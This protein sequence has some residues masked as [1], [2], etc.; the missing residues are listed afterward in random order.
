M[1]NK[2]SSFAGI[3]L[4]TGCDTVT[5]CQPPV[6]AR[7]QAPGQLIAM[8]TFRRLVPTVTAE[9]EGKR[10]G[11]LT[12]LIS[13]MPLCS[14]TLANWFMCRHGSSKLEKAEI[15]QMTVDHLKLLHA[16]GGKG[17][18]DAHALAVDYRSLGFRECVGEVA[19]FLSSLESLQN[20]DPIGTRLVA[21]LSHCA[22][23]MEPLLP[24]PASLPHPHPWPWD[25]PQLSSTFPRRGSEVRVPRRDVPPPPATALLAAYP[26][27]MGCLPTTQQGGAMAVRRIV[28]MATLRGHGLSH[29][30]N[31]LSPALHHPRPTQLSFRAF[32]P[33]SASPSSPPSSGAAQ[34]SRSWGTEIG[35]F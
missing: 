23:E 16:M 12:Y 21:H 9:P 27:P 11:V 13:R 17:Y 32:A 10:L 30:G 35:A 25:L 31:G 6:P 4:P 14:D 5:E 26:S 18:L 8:G 34:P 19:R 28:P 2:A 3:R 24:S 20:A 29:P 1:T 33:F 22:S 15:L 7:R